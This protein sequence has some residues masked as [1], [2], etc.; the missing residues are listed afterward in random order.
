MKDDYPITLI[1]HYIGGQTTKAAFEPTTSAL[2][3]GG[4]KVTLTTSGTTSRLNVAHNKITHK[5]V[6]NNLGYAFEYH[7]NLLT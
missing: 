1:N 4:G 7:K 3:N 5:A 2:T 6:A